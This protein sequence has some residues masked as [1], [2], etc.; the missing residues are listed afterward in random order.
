[1]ISQKIKQTNKQKQQERRTADKVYTFIPFIG[2]T[3]NAASYDMHLCRLTIKYKINL[4]KKSW[5]KRKD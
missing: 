3:N 1:M 5:K 4:E 2:T